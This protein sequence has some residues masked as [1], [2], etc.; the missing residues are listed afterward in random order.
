MS[1]RLFIYYCAIC[2]GWAALVGWALGRI[3]APSG[4]EEA[5]K[6]SKRKK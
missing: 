5:V 6:K 3:L 2:G 1:F 4:V